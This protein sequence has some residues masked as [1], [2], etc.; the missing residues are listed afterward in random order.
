M[1]LHGLLVAQDESD[2]I[3]DLLAFLKDLNVYNTILFFDLGSQDDTFEKALKFKDILYN[4]Q[5]LQ[6]IYTEKLRFDLLEQHRSLYEE[7]DW[8]AMI[9]TDEFYV[10]DPLELI[11]FAEKEKATFIQTY[12]AQFLFTDMDLKEFEKEDSGLPIYERRKYY[13]INYSE[14]RFFKFL[15]E[16]GLFSRSK[17][18]SRRLLNRHYQFRTPCQIQDRIRARLENRK[19]ARDLRGRHEWPQ[20]FST[21]WK[22]YVVSHRSAHFL[23]GND[24]R[25]DLPEGA[26][27]KDYYSKDPLSPVLPQAAKAL[28]KEYSGEINRTGRVTFRESY[29]KRVMEDIR[30]DLLHH[31]WKEAISG[32][33]ILFRYKLRNCERAIRQ[34]C[35]LCAVKT[36]TGAWNLSTSLW[37]F[38]RGKSTGSITAQPNPIQISDNSGVGR[39]TLTWNSRGAKKVEVHVDTAYGQIFDQTGPSGSKA[40]ENWVS[41]HMIFL[42][43]DVSDHLPLTSA[44]TLSKVIVKVIKGKDITL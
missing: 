41:D 34:S 20:I 37:R 21:N 4:P 42:L 19:R 8:I 27:W 35:H 33:V 14:E 38:L 28:A 23:N 5:K 11:R 40:T 2:I 36:K 25:F 13:L 1:K 39:T 9:D 7:G 10:D 29:G 22:D 3:E 32:L 16:Y 17:P 18:C 6:E 43:Q 24:F 26:R 12:Q 44:N 15:P 30:C 31:N